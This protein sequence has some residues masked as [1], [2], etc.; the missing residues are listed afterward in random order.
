MPLEEIAAYRAALLERYANPRIRHLLAQIAADG[1]QKV[2]IRI[3]PTVRADLAAGH[4]PTGAAR[5]LAAWVCHLRGQGAPV[6][7][8][9]AE[10]FSTLVAG[11]LDDAVGRVLAR[12]G[13]DDP[14]LHA[15]VTDLARELCG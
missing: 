6:A 15:A 2:P 14:R 12:L 4:V 8:V 1:S 5:V 11:E 13:A 9:A 10:E 7:D 3:L